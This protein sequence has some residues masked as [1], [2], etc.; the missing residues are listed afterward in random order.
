MGGFVGLRIAARRPELIKSL[1]LVNSDTEADKNN[2]NL[3]NELFTLIVRYFGFVKPLASNILPIFF[4]DSYLKNPENVELWT[5]YWANHVKPTVWRS[6]RG[7][8]DR[9]PFLEL[10]KIKVPTLIIHGDEDKSIP[11]EH[12]EKMA[13]EIVGSKF[14]SIAKTGHQS[15]QEKPNEVNEAIFNWLKEYD[16]S[17]PKTV[18][19]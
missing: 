2:K 9:E 5:E 17:R 7:I 11:K 14:I 18:N 19:A 15:P 16:L 6:I 3:S 8:L 13:R 12:A 4:H 1:I 10:N